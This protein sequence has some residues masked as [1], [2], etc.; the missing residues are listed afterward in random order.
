MH[1]IVHA[2]CQNYSECYKS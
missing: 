2:A 1:R